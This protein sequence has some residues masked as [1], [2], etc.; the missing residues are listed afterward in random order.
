MEPPWYDDVFMHFSDEVGGEFLREHNLLGLR[1]SPQVL[2]HVKPWIITFDTYDVAVPGGLG[3]T[4]TR[5]R[6]AYVSKDV[7][8]F[9]IYRPGFFSK[10]VAMQEFE[11]GYPEFDRA[12]AIQPYGESKAQAVIENPKIRKLIQSLLLNGNYPVLKAENHGWWDGYQTLCYE[13][14][15]IITDVGRLKSILELFSEVLNHLCRIGLATED[16]P[17]CML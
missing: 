11:T 17:N 12:F 6:A 4:S 13:E 7:F 16:D 9:K 14:G 8:E 10:L 5:V 2:V 15:E 3:T 1:K